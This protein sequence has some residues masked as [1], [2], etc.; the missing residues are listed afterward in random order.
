MDIK[1]TERAIK[2]HE[3]LSLPWYIRLID[4]AEIQVDEIL[5]DVGCGGC[6]LSTLKRRKFRI[7]GLDN[8]QEFI[9][10]ARYRAK[11]RDGVFLVKGDAFVTPFPNNFF[12]A[13]I[14]CAFPHDTSGF[15][16]VLIDEMARVLKPGKKLAIVE[17]VI[18][19]TGRSGMI[20]S[21]LKKLGLDADINK[22]FWIV[23]ARKPESLTVL[24][25]LPPRDIWDDEDYPK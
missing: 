24:P 16:N 11:D 10:L 20:H 9:D 2:K 1:E 19:R 22:E 5:L 23:H 17:D 15:T 4:C 14:A 18:V 3:K 21:R 12:D 13:V 6:L 25:G 8:D 7:V